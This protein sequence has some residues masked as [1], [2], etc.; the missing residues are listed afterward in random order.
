[1]SGGPH[2]LELTASVNE[3]ESARSLP[4][5]VSI[6][7]SLTQQGDAA[8]SSFSSAPVREHLDGCVVQECYQETLIASGQGAVTFAVSAGAQLFVVEDGTRV[9][10]IAGDALQDARALV[11]SRNARITGLAIPPDYA[12]SRAVFVAWSESLPDGSERLNVTRYRELLGTLAE[13]AAILTGLP[14]PPEGSAP[15]AIDDRGRLYVALSAHGYSD[16][17]CAV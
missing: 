4:L 16:Q 10:V 13:G 12:R 2:T 15:I 7:S 9:R 5:T 14:I 3:I 6:R 17:R 1:M 8:M 11:M